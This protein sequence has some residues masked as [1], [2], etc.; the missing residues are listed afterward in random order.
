MQGSADAGVPA[1]HTGCWCTALRGCSGGSRA[2]TANPCWA[3]RW[4]GAEW[5]PQPVLHPSALSWPQVRR[6]LQHSPGGRSSLSR[7]F[8]SWVP[9]GQGAGLRFPLAAGA[10]PQSRLPTVKRSRSQPPPGFSLMWLPKDVVTIK[11]S[12]RRGAKAG[13]AVGFLLAPVRQGAALPCRRSAS[14]PIPLPAPQAPF[15]VIY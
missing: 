15:A 2:V 9:P 10:Q 6:Q 1:G 7:S 11:V 13:E 4:L 14:V 5:A 3:Q 8:S 12:V